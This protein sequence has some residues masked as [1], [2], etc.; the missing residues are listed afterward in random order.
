MLVVRPRFFFL[1]LSSWLLSLLLFSF[2]FCCCC[3]CKLLFSS[4]VVFN[5][6]FNAVDMF[7][8]F[9]MSFLMG[10]LMGSLVGV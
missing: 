8:C 3:L 5:I 4:V 6:A 9:L 1:L 7:S 2:C 10:S